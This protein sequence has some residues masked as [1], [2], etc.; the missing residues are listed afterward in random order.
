MHDEFEN[1]I[2]QDNN[3]GKTCYHVDSAKNQ[4]GVGDIRKRWTYVLQK[5]A[6]ITKAGICAWLAI[7]WS[8]FRKDS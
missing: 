6:K 3:Y 4:T 5:R 8:V 7:C 1:L 2:T